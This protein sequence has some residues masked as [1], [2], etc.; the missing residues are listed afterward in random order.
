MGYE[1]LLRDFQAFD[2]VLARIRLSVPATGILAEQLFLIREFLEDKVK[3]PEQELLLKWNPRFKEF[4]NAQLVLG[5]LGSAVAVLWNQPDGKLR[6]YLKKIFSGD[7]SQGSSPNQAKDFFYEF[8]LASVL[9]E[10]G[11]TVELKEPDIIIS[12]NGL[13]G[14]LGIACKYPSSEQQLHPHLSKGYKQLR[15]QSLDGFVAVGI[16]LIVLK[17]AYPRGVNYIDFNQGSKHPVDVLQVQVD[18]ATKNLVASR[19]KDYPSEAPIDG[20]FV[21]FTMGGIFG[22]PP[23]FTFAT[24]TTMQCGAHNPMEEQ[25]RKIRDRILALNK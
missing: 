20:L 24:A 3:L 6:T 12:E 17:E 11:F 15:N 18:Q 8:W 21:S 10:A 25:I 2:E 13:P 19:A 16:D 7:L 23:T 14:P 22:S 1:K 5:R 4:Y 9:A